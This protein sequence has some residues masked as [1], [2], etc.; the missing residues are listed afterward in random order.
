VIDGRAL[1][2]LT[3]PFG[4]LIGVVRREEK[5]YEMEP[6]G[7]LYD[8]LPMMRLGVCH[9]DEQ[10]VVVPDFSTF[11]YMLAEYIT[12]ATARIVIP[13]SS[14]EAKRFAELPLLL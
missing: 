3:N 9:E 5:D 11:A 14:P 2:G 4:S 1:Q 7:I 12:L 8:S 10:V 6:S 13:A